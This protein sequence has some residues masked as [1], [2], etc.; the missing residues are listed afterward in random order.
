M[1]QHKLKKGL[2]KKDGRKLVVK[3]LSSENARSRIDNIVRKAVVNLAEDSVD[4]LNLEFCESF[5]APGISKFS[6]KLV[7]SD[8]I[9]SPS[10]SV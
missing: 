2:C 4:R 5:S 6:F 7:L 9:S 8:V 3:E 1:V 10:F